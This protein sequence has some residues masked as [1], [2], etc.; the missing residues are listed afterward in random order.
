[1]TP[2]M[3][4]DFL[5]KAGHGLA[6]FGRKSRARELLVEAQQLAERHRLNAWYF[7]L[8]QALGGLDSSP[9]HEP[10]PAA[11]AAAVGDLSAIEEVAIGLREYALQST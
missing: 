8:E 1:M 9:A 3:T 5:F 11:P 2:S 6:Q 4:C 7:R 10:E